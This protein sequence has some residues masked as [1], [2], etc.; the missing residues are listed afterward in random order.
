ML[1]DTTW[2]R[3]QLCLAVT[4]C[5]LAA[6]TGCD[7]AAR[8]Q[9]TPPPP[10]PPRTLGRC[11]SGQF[12][13][14]PAKL[15]SLAKDSTTR[16]GCPVE[17]KEHYD[18]TGKDGLPAFTIA[19]LDDKATTTTR[20]SHKDQAN[21]CCYQWVEQCPGGR[22]LLAESARPIVAP[23]RAGATWGRDE[24]V[25]E[26]AP[27]VRE[28]VAA[29]WLADALAEHASIASFARATL[30]LL[31]VAAP[32]ELIAE[33]QRASLDEIE[34][35]RAAFALASRYAGRAIEPG[36]WPIAAPRDGGLA[37][38]A[39]DVLVEG[40][41]GE[42]VAALCASR[43]AAGC[44]DAELAAT[45]RRI[46]NDEARHAALAWKTL[47]WAVRAHGDDSLLGDLHAA[48][49]KLRAAAL[50][51][52]LPEA[53]A[54]ADELARHG[55]LDARARARVLRDAWSEIIEPMLAR[56]A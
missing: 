26:L 24:R 28:I 15:K 44:G 43:A 13:A 18:A 3:E 51:D 33:T 47:A 2:L 1:R 54:E 46:A 16:L 21:D 9:S 36:A 40:C 17:L 10:P 56:L 5:S 49:A 35:A 30:E 52:A 31:A 41:I 29:G 20:A 50:V 25:T 45:L 6:G 23:A 27:T 11:P 37:R 14:P 48:V 22:A 53:D 8:A 7:E 32:P 39:R 12:C 42:T 55:R 34:H 4:V 38:L 19:N